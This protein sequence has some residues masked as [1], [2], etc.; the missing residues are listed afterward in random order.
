MKSKLLGILLAG[1]AFVAFGLVGS[2]DYED[3]LAEQEHY[4][5]M[6]KQ[7]LDTNGEQGWPDYNENYSQGCTS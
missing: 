3:A 1:A 7:N 4:C 5:E 2:M 6:V